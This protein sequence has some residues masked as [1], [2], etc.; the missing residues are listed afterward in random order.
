MFRAAPTLLLCFYISHSYAA[1]LTDLSAQLEQIRLQH[2][3]GA[4]SWTLVERD[5]TVQQGGLG[6]YSRA[7]Q[8]PV[9]AHSVFRVGSLTKLITALSLHQLADQGR[10]DLNAPLRAYLPDIPLH[11][12]YPAPV[13]LNMLLEHS[14][15]LQDLT[16]T[17]FNYPQPLSLTEAFRVA[18]DARQVQWP[19]GLHH[20]YSNVGAG[21]AGRVLEQIT[22]QN[23]DNWIAEHLLQPLNMTA[24]ST[25]YS[26]QLQ[27]QLVTGYDSD[28]RTVIPYWHTL[29]RPF[30]ALNTTAAD[31]SQLLKLLINRGQTTGTTLLSPA[32]ITAMEQPQSTHAA[33]LGHHYG[34]GAGL[35]RW[36]R[37]GKL[38]LG[39]GGDGDGYLAHFAYNPDS[40]RGMFVV[41]NAYHY[42]ALQALRTPLENW[43]VDTLPI[44]ELT[45]VQ[46]TTEQ[47]TP[48]TGRW[49]AITSRFPGRKHQPDTVEVQIKDGQLSYSEGAHST[50]LLAT[51]D[52]QFRTANDGAASHIFFEY[53]GEMY[54]QSDLGNYRR[55]P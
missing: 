19:P 30:G 38:L 21:Y 33:Q 54:W 51:A 45:P 37:D 46:L 18:P 17:E 53:Q 25:E 40:Q 23:W 20:S 13:T 27:Q 32:S 29:F 14:A 52:R 50:T 7:R 2:K 8:R 35:Y 39:H 42:R 44:P 43:V 6:F 49:Q 47:L 41:I 16:N 10:V 34:Y 28:R 22:G 9:S 11:N 26:A 55:L 12:A 15:G 4:V 31:F 48:L 1:P 3:I 36:Y 5:Q 24:S